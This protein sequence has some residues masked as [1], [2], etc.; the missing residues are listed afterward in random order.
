M[1]TTTSAPSIREIHALGLGF[2][3]VFV[4]EL[5]TDGAPNLQPRLRGE[6]EF[7]STA[8]PSPMYEG[9]TESA[10]SQILDRI[11]AQY[12]FPY[13]AY[14]PIFQKGGWGKVELARRGN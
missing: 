6:P 3:S 11:E 14:L 2:R 13:V 9:W 10:L 5:P 8:F 12:D 7:V 4:D 1:D